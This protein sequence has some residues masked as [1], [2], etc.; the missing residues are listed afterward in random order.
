MKR[1]PLIL[2]LLLLGAAVGTE[3]GSAVE[4]EPVAEAAARWVAAV[5]RQEPALVELMSRD[6]RAY[7]PRLR[8]HALRADARSLQSLPFEEQLQV[9]FLRHLAPPDALAS[10]DEKELILFAREQGLF[11]MNLRSHDTLEEI[12]VEGDRAQGRLAKFGR[13]DRLEP[14]L[15]YLVREEG[16]WKVELRG[17]Q[18][19]ATLDFAAFVK[20]SGLDEAEAAFFLLEMRLMRKVTSRDLDPP[21]A[22]PRAARRL[23]PVARDTTLP[24][25]RVIALREAVGAALPPAATLEDQAESLRYVLEPGDTLP[26]HPRVR[27]REISAESVLLA[28]PEGEVRLGLGGKDAYLGQRLRAGPTRRGLADLAAQGDG[29]PGPMA[30]WRNVGLRERPLLLQQGWLTPVVAEHG[31]LEGLRVRRLAA[32]SFWDQIGLQEGDLLVA[33]NG[34]A[35]DSLDAWKEFVRV[36]ERETEVVVALHRNTRKLRFRTRTISPTRPGSPPS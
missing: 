32:G 31:G 30:Q 8:E 26:G 21:G 4:S 17:E 28:V 10:M 36:A 1:S 33:A 34:R 13:L 19:K 7:Y 9:L 15:H 14:G 22:S 3:S 23:E 20:R 25:L 2:T 5:H 27:V 6:A 35:L 29:K 16:A 24:P 12:R 18:E 11:G